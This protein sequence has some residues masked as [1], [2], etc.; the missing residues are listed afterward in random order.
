MLMTN[1]TKNS[2]AVQTDIT[3]IVRSA[4]RE[5]MSFA[6]GYS[7]SSCRWKTL[8]LSRSIRLPMLY[9][10]RLKSV[11]NW[12]GHGRYASMPTRYC[13]EKAY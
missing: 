2:F 4:V 3:A 1:Y 9:E 6:T 11:A 12:G 13:G 5:P 7:A 8:S 10:S